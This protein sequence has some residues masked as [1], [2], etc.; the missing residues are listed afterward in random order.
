MGFWGD[1]KRERERAD[2]FYVPKGKAA[3]VYEFVVCMCMCT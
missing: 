1:V 3:D 2:T